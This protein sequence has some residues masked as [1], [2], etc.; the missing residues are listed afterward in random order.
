[1]DLTLPGMMLEPV[2]SPQHQFAEPQR[3]RCTSQ[4][5]VGRFF[6]SEPAST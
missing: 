5:F 2:R 6:E 4:R 1:V 3:G